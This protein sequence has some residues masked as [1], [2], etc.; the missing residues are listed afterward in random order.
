MKSNPN[1]TV[2]LMRISIVVALIVALLSW[3][4]GVE[5]FN[6]IVRAGVSF[7]IMFLLLIGTL[8]AF[9]KTALPQPGPDKNEAGRG[10]LVDFSVGED[11]LTSFMQSSD[12]PGQVDKDLSLGLPDSK[13]QADIIRRMGWGGE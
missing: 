12:V 8:R 11:D 13:K 2:W 4:N 7:G 3:I 9:E 1:F 10:G 5:I 6:V